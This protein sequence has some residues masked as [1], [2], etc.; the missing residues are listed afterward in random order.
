L[1]L[2]VAQ[3]CAA[4][5]IELTFDEAYY[6]LWARWP[7]AGYFDHPPMVAWTIAASEALFG[8]SELGVRALFALEGAC[9][10]PMAAW[11]GWRLYGEAAAP[12]LILIGAPLIAGAP[13]AT[14]DTPLAFFWTLALLGLVEVWRGSRWAWALVGLATGAAGL[15]KMT[16]GFLAMGI[17][18][19]LIVTP[20]L[21]RQWLRPG[22]Y[23]A[24][25]L[26]L[27]T[28]SPFLLWNLAH[29]FA[30]FHKQGGRLAAARFAPGY[31]AEFLGAQFALFNPLTA[32]AALWGLARKTPSPFTGEGGGGG[33][34]PQAARE[35]Q[36]LLLAATAPALAYF[37]LHALHDRVQGNWTAPLYP[38]L[39]VLAARY[40]PRRVAGAAAALGLAAA[41]AA[42]LHLATA[43][44]SFGP[45]DPSLRIGG[46]RDLAAQVYAQ[47]GDSR[48]IL[49]E[50]Y[51]ATSLLSY[52][53][54]GAPPVAE[55]GEP[56]R[57]SFRPPVDLSG[58]GLAFGRPG[59]AEALARAHLRATP[60][61]TLRRRVGGVELETYT[62]FAIA[63]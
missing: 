25:A 54:P 17:A 1:A 22:P 47:A 49:A 63:P 43:W 62:L 42:Y 45:A 48:F 13:L 33:A 16:A 59:M 27:T 60:L 14:P 15:A 38:A 9:L 57:W 11:I 55:L 36:R 34:P 46:W 41:A 30:T 28:L 20:S 58:P 2:A 19:A 32:G 21:R 23:A 52:Y 51:A 53:G 26:A 6:A 39:A 4:S 61:A 31:L 40:V 5:R 44:P 18:L 24:A 3:L 56:E 10:A 35:P 8:R 29:G 12:A 37:T 7:Q 50:G